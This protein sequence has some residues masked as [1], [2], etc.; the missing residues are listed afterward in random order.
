MWLKAVACV[1]LATITAMSLLALRQHR[2]DQMHQ[3]TA[4]HRKMRQSRQAL[5]QLQV[6]ISRQLEPGQLQTAVQ[7]AELV[8]E[9]VVPSSHGPRPVTLTQ[10]ETRH[11]R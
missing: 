11:D 4:E 1:I 8:L 7:Q 2:I 5:W 10:A 9:P 6:S 3:M